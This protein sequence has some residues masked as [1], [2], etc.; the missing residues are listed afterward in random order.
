MQ[1]LLVEPDYYT[2]Y[3]PLGLLKLAAFHKG[4]GDEVMLVRGLQP[5]NFSPARVYVTS[6]F[7]WEWKPVWEA[8]HFYKALFPRSEVWLGGIYASL[9]PDHAR[10]SG[11]DVVWEGLFPE[12]EGLLP[13]YSLV[14][15]WDS[16]LLFAT[17]GCTRRC[18]FCAVPRLEGKAFVVHRTVREMVYPGHKK[19]V[20]FDNNILSLP[21]WKDI[22]S[23]LVELGLEVDFN[24]GL[25]CRYLTP[26][27]A[28]LLAKMRCPL[29]RMAFDYSGIRPFVERAIKM[30]RE[31]GISGRRIIFYVLYNYIDTS[32]DF[33]YRVR[34]LLSWG[35]V[36][37]PMRYEPLCTLEKGRYI[38]PRWTAEEL[39]LV[40]RA[41]RVLGYGGA[42]PPY[43]ALVE[44]FQ[45]A[46]NFKEAFS[47]RSSENGYWA[48]T[49]G[50]LEMALEH[51]QPVKKHYFPAWRR[52]KDWR[53]VIPVPG[54]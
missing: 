37:Y 23:E 44:K 24:Q 43:R 48:L 19:V 17:R 32:E 1:V 50:L 16:S 40:E 39:E 34:D 14:P 2:R 10:L 21:Q 6:L 3:P 41:R 42:L 28:A 45:R 18:G 47:L 20:F 13:D 54:R 49:P 5:I 25:D 4:R 52:E 8:V 51:R 27:A 53:K 12:A 11:A 30:L 33:F 46:R 15:Q 7:T 31:V 26:D 36:V 38:S 29:V 9:L 22:F 35:V